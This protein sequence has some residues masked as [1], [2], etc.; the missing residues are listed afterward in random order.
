MTQQFNPRFPSPTDVIQIIRSKTSELAGLARDVFLSPYDL[1]L[2]D[3]ATGVLGGFCQGDDQAD[4]PEDGS[5]DW[6]E[7]ENYIRETFFALTRPI[8]RIWTPSGY[9]YLLPALSMNSPAIAGFHSLSLFGKARACALTKAILV[10]GQPL[11]G[12]SRNLGLRSLDWHRVFDYD[13]EMMLAENVDAEA[14]HLDDKLGDVMWYDRCLDRSGRKRLIGM[15]CESPGKLSKILRNFRS[16]YESAY[17]YLC[18][19]GGLHGLHPQ[20]HSSNGGDQP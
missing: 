13:S 7:A 6:S 2:I 20:N 9:H 15:L 4:A 11:S 3:R 8:P 12:F 19:E 17:H 14:M 1:Y 10:D 18:L 16:S 5:G